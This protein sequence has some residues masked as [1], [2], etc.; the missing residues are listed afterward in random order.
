[1]NR[2]LQ[3]REHITEEE[4]YLRLRTKAAGSTA[5]AGLGGSNHY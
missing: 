1:L 5:D 4:A 2:I 3:K